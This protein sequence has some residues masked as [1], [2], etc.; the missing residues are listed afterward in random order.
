[1]SGRMV[2]LFWIDLLVSL[3]QVLAVLLTILSSVGVVVGGVMLIVFALR[4][5]ISLAGVSAPSL[6]LC[7]LFRELRCGVSFWLCSRLL[8]FI[9]G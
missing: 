5:N 9:W 3:L 4:V 6:G 8:L 1:M 2:A 7:S